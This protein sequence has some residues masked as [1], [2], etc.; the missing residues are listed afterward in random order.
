MAASPMAPSVSTVERSNSWNRS[1]ATRESSSLGGERE[2][3]GKYHIWKV[4]TPSD[5][6]TRS[7]EAGDQRWRRFWTRWVNQNQPTQNLWVEVLDGGRDAGQQGVLAG[8][9]DHHGV[10]LGQLLVDLHANGAQTG[11]ISIPYCLDSLEY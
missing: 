5:R 4:L 8:G 9:G 3:E 1:M 7:E 11:Q 2:R 6:S 10:Q